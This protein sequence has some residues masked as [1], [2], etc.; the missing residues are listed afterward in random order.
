MLSIAPEL[1]R[2]QKTA[3]VEHSCVAAKTTKRADDSFLAFLK[4]TDEAD[5]RP[6]SARLTD[7]R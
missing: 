2:Q 3:A 4:P 1:D 6:K 5:D 7:I